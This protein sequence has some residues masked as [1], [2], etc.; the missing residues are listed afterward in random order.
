[1]E[2]LSGLIKYTRRL[3]IVS[4]AF[5]T[6]KV[7][8]SLFFHSLSGATFFPKRDQSHLLSQEY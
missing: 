2:T 1:M 3:P 8:L 7:G 5:V 6:G 4:V